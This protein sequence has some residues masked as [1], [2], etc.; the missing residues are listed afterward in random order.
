MVI[1]VPG[2]MASASSRRPASRSCATPWPSSISRV[3]DSTVMR[4]T[5]AIE[6]RASPR[7]PKVWMFS[8]SVR[9]WILL[10]ACRS[11]ATFSSSGVMPQPSSE[12]AISPMPPRRT[13]TSTRVAPA[14]SA[15]S[16]SSLTIDAG[17]ST[18]S[19]AAI[20]STS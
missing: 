11:S 10:V 9:S 8:R 20:M 4:E 15:F 19:P 3:R 5:E 6:G 14:S 2:V 13:D 12:M 17:R 16:T 18:T 1:R 7:K